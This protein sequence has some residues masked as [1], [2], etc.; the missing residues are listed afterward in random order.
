VFGEDELVRSFYGREEDGGV[1]KF[2]LIAT[3]FHRVM[4]KNETLEVGAEQG[5]LALK[6]GEDELEKKRKRKDE[7]VWGP[8]ERIF[9]EVV[10]EGLDLKTKRVKT[11]TKTTLPGRIM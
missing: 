9:S 2:D 11:M 4:V 6:E 10:L 8:W 5:A 1:E 3:V 7:F